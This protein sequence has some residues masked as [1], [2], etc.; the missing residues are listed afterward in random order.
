M[1]SSLC[2]VKHMQIC[3]HLQEANQMTEPSKPTGPPPDRVKVDKPWEEAVRDALTK[4]R[5]KDGWPQDRSRQPPP[6]DK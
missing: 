1:I 5:P 4:K 3:R 2:F 6:K